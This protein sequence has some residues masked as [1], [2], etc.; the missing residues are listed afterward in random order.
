MIR[1][2]KSHEV[3]NLIQDGATIYTC[4]FGL[5]GYPD[6]IAMAIKESFL[7][8]GHPNN[9]S[10]YY[11]AGI[12]NTKDRGIHHF[13][14][15]GL[16]KRVVGG[17]FG[18]GG[19]D[20]NRLIME[21]KIE[22]YN[23]PQGVLALMPRNIAGNRP[24]LITKVGIGTFVD[25]RIEG[26]KITTKTTED[27][28]KV[29]E[30]DGEEWLYFKAPKIDVAIIRGSVADEKGNMTLHRE[31]VLLET[32]SVAQAAKACGGIVIAQVEQ[33]VKADTLHPKD[34]KVPGLVI[35]YL[36][37]AKPEN[38]Y[39]TMGTYFNPAFAGDIKIPTA[40]IKPLEMDE[41]KII[42]RRA[43]MELV[44][45]AAVNLGI[46][47]PEGVANIAAEENIAHLMTL[48]TEAGVVGGIP[49]GG[50]D[51]GHA[52]NAEAVI[53][54][55]YQFDFYDGG[56]IDV[57]FLG[58]AQMDR[59]GNINVSKFGPKTAGCG[60]FINITQNAKKVVYCGTFTA[61]GLKIKVAD[62]KLIIEQE[63]RNK[64]FLQDVEQITFSGKY[65]AQIGQ[66][67][68]Y[69]TERAVFKLTKEGIELTEI[70]PGIDIEKDILQHMEFTPITTNV[71]LMD[72]GIFR[73]IW[74]GLSK[75]ISSG[76]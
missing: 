6:E 65:A 64:K 41:R 29:V 57:A 54:Q 4:G 34:V 62:E 68:L 48:T 5:A 69:V 51:F 26:G 9:L 37:V 18:V 22:A 35:D 12:G 40:S 70:A 27:L 8:T 24:A 3:G 19:P 21:N 46:G 30:F 44:P 43:A 16:L 17:H 58:L 14:Q 76:S 53:D 13:A 61:G 67:V 2:I 33:I 39:Q 52:V 74:G 49:A 7:T 56:G 50:L 71:K 31:G 15:E 75:I 1:E 10:V 32:I 55:P 38:H 36:M 63:G 20:I 73:E 11:A 59:F 28:V 47:M 45:N 23:F 72:P 60:G 66:P 25:P 42:A